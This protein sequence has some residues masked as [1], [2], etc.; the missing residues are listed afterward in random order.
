MGAY[1]TKPTTTKESEDGSGNGLKY[2]GSSMQGWR[3][4]QEVI[5]IILMKLKIVLAVVRFT[6]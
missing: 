4:S 6:C 5:S 3:V 2:G 1:M